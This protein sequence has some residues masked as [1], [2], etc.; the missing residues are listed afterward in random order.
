MCSSHSHTRASTRGW[1]TA[2]SQ[3]PLF[4][5]SGKKGNENVCRVSIAQAAKV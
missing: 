3:H 2:I 1:K 4:L 5:F